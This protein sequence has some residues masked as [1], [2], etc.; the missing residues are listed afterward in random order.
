MRASAYTATQPHETLK[1]MK[2]ENIMHFIFYR[3]GWPF[4]GRSTLLTI[5][6]TTTTTMKMTMGMRMRNG[7]EEDGN[8]GDNT[9]TKPPRCSA[10]CILTLPYVSTLYNRREKSTETILCWPKWIWNRLKTEKF[11]RRTF[12][13]HS[14]FVCRVCMYLS[15]KPRSACRW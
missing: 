2:N 6:T 9:W 12:R 3:M 8:D 4:F 5:L 14:V 13:S 11:V 15:H 10:A 7:D 1:I